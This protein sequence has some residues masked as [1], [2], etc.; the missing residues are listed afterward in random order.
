LTPDEAARVAEM[1]RLDVAIA[2]HYLVP[3]EEVDD[4]LR[5]VPEHDSSGARLALAPE[6]GET[7]VVDGSNTYIEGA[8]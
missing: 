6:V 3:N 2:C 8:A 7:V 4:F 1:L 5:L